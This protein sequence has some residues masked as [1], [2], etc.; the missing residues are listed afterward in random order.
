MARWGHTASG[1][2]F[3]DDWLRLCGYFCNC[4]A[5]ATSPVCARQNCPLPAGPVL[6]SR[7]N[8][9][10]RFQALLRLAAQHNLRVHTLA[11]SVQEL[12][13]VL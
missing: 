11:A 5:S 6:P 4:V 3:G 2:G 13:N 1:Y 7:I 8:T 9:A 10:P 12:E